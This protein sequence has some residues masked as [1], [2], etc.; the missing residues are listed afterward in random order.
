MLISGCP[1]GDL[2]K[3]STWSLNPDRL[4]EGLI[5]HRRHI[6]PCW[7]HEIKHSRTY[8]ATQDVMRSSIQILK[9]NQF[10]KESQVAEMVCWEKT[11]TYKNTK[12]SVTTSNAG[13]RW[14]SRSSCGRRSR[15][16]LRYTW[17]NVTC[18]V[19]PSSETGRSAADGPERRTSHQTASPW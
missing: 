18:I 17:G 19:L 8:T 1:R 7:N 11:K 16:M 9:K 5:I 12:T 14:T 4:D 3:V 2:G 15:V 13:D 6:E 10:L